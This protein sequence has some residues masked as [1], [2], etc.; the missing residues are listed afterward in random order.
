MANEDQ[1]F[2]RRVVASV[3]DESDDWPTGEDGKPLVEVMKWFG[4]KLKKIPE[5]HRASAI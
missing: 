4:G 5:Q 3:T 1:K 2:L